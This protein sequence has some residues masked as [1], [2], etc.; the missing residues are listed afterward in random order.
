[1]IHT[2]DLSVFLTILAHV[3]WKHDQ[4]GHNDK[5]STF[6]KMIFVVES[7]TDVPLFTLIDRLYPTSTRHI[8]F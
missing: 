4:S 6:L 5:D 7:I 3:H 2:A 8:Y 1:M